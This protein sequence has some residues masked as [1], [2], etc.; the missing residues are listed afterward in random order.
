MHI[1]DHTYNC[2]PGWLVVTTLNLLTDWILSWEACIRKGL[3]DD[4]D[5]LRSSAVSKRKKTSAQKRYL[6]RSEVVIVDRNKI[7]LW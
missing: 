4:C 3:A 7:G 1:C 6:H 2:H 5:I